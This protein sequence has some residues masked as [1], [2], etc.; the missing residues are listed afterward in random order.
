MA[1]GLDSDEV[2]LY[3]YYTDNNQLQLDLGNG[4]IQTINNADKKDCGGTHPLIN[5][6][7][8][9]CNV[10]MVQIAKK[11]GKEIFYNYMDKF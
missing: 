4:V 6:V 1:F 2:S 3:D 11:V 8:F 5:A 10:G 9:S 7:I